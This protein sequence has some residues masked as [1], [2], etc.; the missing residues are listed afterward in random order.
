NKT[1]TSLVSDGDKRQKQI[2]KSKKKAKTD[3]YQEVTDQIVDLMETL[4][5]GWTKS[6]TG[7]SGLPLNVSS[8]VNYRGMNVLL[9]GISAM[10]G[11]FKS[12]TWGAYKQWAEKGGQVKKGS[13]G[14]RAIFYKTLLIDEAKSSTGKEEKIPMLKSFVCSGQV[15]LAT[16]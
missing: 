13:Q 16:A 5:S 7:A 14:T 12:S 11:G 4:G 10:V 3:I 1:D 8:G 2:I 9:L 6:W 15:K